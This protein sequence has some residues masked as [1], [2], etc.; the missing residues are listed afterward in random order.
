MLAKSL[1]MFLLAKLISSNL[2]HQTT[3][4]ELEFELEPGRF[5][6]EINAA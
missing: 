3:V 6:K 1:G 5:P 2:W 4:E